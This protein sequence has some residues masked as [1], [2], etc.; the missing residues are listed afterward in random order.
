MSRSG[1]VSAPS[2]AP[3]VV[4]AESATEMERYGIVRVP[5]DYFH[6]GGF[7]YTS[8]KEAIAQA[9]RQRPDGGL[10]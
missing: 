5:I 10:H 2:P 9:K 3:E 6:V 7:R 8:L 4:D 1:T